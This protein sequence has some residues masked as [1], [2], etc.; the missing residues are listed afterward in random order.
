MKKYMFPL[1]A[2]FALTIGAA[3]AQTT[4]PAGGRPSPEQMAARQSE[5]MTQELGLSADQ[6]NKV[7]QIMAARDQEMQAMRGQ[8]QGGTATRE[9]MR[10]Q[11]MAGRTKYDAQFKTVLTPDQ[12]T[13]YTAMQAERMQR[14]RGGRGM[15]PRRD[16]TDTKG[17]VKIKKDKLK[18]KAE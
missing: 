10:D 7:Q 9:Q 1:L 16:S 14:G 17:K 5:R 2:A 3:S 11:M 12:Y 4:P 15:G 8:M 18:V 6:T 13:K